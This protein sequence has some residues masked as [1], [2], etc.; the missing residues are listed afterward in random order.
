MQGMV[1]NT[2]GPISDSA[3]FAF[4]WDNAT[5]A[6]MSNWG[7]IAYILVAFLFA[8]LMDVKGSYFVVFFPCDNVTTVKILGPVLQRV[9]DLLKF[10]AKSGT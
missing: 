4:H 6:T 9:L 10:L 5:I 2:W 7:P 1:W 3:E 8:W